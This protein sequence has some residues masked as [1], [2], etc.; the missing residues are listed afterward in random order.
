MHLQDYFVRRRCEPRV[1]A[2]RYDGADAVSPAPG[3]IDAL[4]AADAVIICPSN[5]LISIAP[6][7]KVPGVRR[8]MEESKAIVAAI[9]PLVEGRALKGPA[10]EMMRD[11]GYESSAAGVARFYTGLLDLFVL[12]ERDGELAPMIAE[13]GIAVAM[14]DTIMR[15]VDDKKRLA[16]SVVDFMRIEIGRRK[17]QRDRETAS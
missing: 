14:T 12:D 8:A 7:L 17:K 13:T 4:R 6:I 9:T 15:T 3:V 5:P 16:S 11:L 2:I 10:A 1:R